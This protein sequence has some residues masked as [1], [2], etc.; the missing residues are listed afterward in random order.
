MKYTDKV[1]NILIAMTACIIWVSLVD[2]AKPYLYYGRTIAQWYLPFVL[3]SSEPTFLQKF[4][5]SCIVAPIWETLTYIILPIKLA[6][7]L[8]PELVTL[9]MICAGLLFGWEHNFGQHGVLI[10][11]VL[12]IAMGWVFI[13]NSDYYSPIIF[14]SLWN[15][16]VVFLAKAYN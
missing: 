13:K 12:G 5:S 4:F 11:G 6:Q 10:Q 3:V 14:H 7:R 16:F 8:T 1:K 9:V 2:M 15:I